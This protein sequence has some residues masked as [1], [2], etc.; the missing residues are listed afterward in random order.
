[1]K[2][3]TRNTRIVFC[4][5]VTDLPEEYQRSSIKKKNHPR[6]FHR[7]EL[8]KE[9]LIMYHRTELMK[10]IAKKIIE[11]YTCA[12]D[13]IGVVQKLFLGTRRTVGAEMSVPPFEN[14]EEE[15]E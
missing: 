9:I 4:S 7:S 14:E 13:L 15:E 11:L 8:M 2:E 12:I 1:M 3:T 5:F 10:E 6:N